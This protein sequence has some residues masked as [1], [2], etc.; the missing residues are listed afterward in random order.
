MNSDPRCN[1]YWTI[2]KC[3][4]SLF[5]M[6]L[7]MEQYQVLQKYFHFHLGRM[8]GPYRQWNTNTSNWFTTV[9]WWFRSR[10]QI[11]TCRKVYKVKKKA[12]SPLFPSISRLREYTLLNQWKY[13]RLYV[14]ISKWKSMEQYYTS[15]VGEDLPSIDHLQLWIY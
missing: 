5:I 15:C 12:D 10:I 8:W 1:T 9:Y 6:K 2:C 7:R 3:F 4:Q 11:Q 13:D 14:E